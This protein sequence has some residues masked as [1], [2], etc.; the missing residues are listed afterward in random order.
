MIHRKI[1]ILIDKDVMTVGKVGCN[2]PNDI[3]FG[4]R[5]VNMKHAVVKKIG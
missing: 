1:K 3:V 5:D 4:G 2:P